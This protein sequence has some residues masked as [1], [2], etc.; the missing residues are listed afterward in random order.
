MQATRL[1][2]YCAAASAY[3][4]ARKLVKLRNAKYRT[5]TAEV[6][7]LMVDKVILTTVSAVVAPVM[8]P[9]FAYSDLRGLELF[10][11]PEVKTVYDSI[12]FTVKRDIS[13]YFFD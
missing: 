2:K 8:L 7:M 9:V 4:F 13:D 3:G 5:Y 6:P 1:E 12:D 10:F 11:R